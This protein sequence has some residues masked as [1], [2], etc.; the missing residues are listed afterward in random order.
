RRARADRL[1]AR[2]ARGL[3]PALSPTH[4]TTGVT[5]SGWH[6]FCVPAGRTAGAAAIGPPP[7]ECDVLPLI[8]AGWGAK[9]RTRGR[10]A[11][12]G[13]RNVALGGGGRRMGCDTSHPAEAGAGWGAGA[14]VDRGA[15]S[16]APAR[17]SRRGRRACAGRGS[18]RRRR[19]T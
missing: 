8:G 3:P 5:P 15:V 2:R 10:R 4:T 12:D 16:P 14:R 13:V 19:P 17:A 9:R 11:W 1:A 18:R 7:V 6:P